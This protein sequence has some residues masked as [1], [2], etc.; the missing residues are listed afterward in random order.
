MNKNK[1]VILAKP[2]NNVF[3]IDKNKINEFN[4]GIRSNKLDKILKKAKMIQTT[5][6]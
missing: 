5:N 3:I 4:N 1:F 6:K 2:V